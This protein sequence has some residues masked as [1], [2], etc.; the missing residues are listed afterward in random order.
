MIYSR[1]NAVVFVQ[2]RRRRHQARKSRPLSERSGRG[3][4]DCSV[5]T[6]V[7]RAKIRSEGR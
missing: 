6:V 1:H 3:Q 4:G 5:S 7:R 2:G